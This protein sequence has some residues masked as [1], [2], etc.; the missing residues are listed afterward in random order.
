MSRMFGDVQYMLD[1][2]EASKDTYSCLRPPRPSGAL[3]VTENGREIYGSTRPAL[4]S[5][6]C[7]DE[8]ECMME[9]GHCVRTVHA[10]VQAIALAARIG[11]SLRGA[12]IYSVNKPCFNC[13][14]VISHTGIKRIVY[15]F[16]AYDESR[17]SE[18]E[19]AA[20]L[21]VDHL[22]FNEDVFDE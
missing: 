4:G 1:C 5:V 12:T 11:A 7:E 16:V 17:T 14:K 19:Y 13:V 20:G 6:S 22:P 8:G 2:I 9:N 18:A 10:E 15:A 3:I 21:L